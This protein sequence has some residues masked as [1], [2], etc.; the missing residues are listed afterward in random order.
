MNERFLAIPL[1]RAR[2]D[3]GDQAKEQRCVMYGAEERGNYKSYREVKVKDIERPVTILEVATEKR[4]E[5]EEVQA[6]AV[7][8]DKGV[9]HEGWIVLCEVACKSG[10]VRTEYDKVIHKWAVV[11]QEFWDVQL[12][13]KRCRCGECKYEWFLGEWECPKELAIFIGLMPTEEGPSKSAKGSKEKK[14]AQHPTRGCGRW[15]EMVEEEAP[16]QSSTVDNATAVAKS[17]QK[18]EGKTKW[19]KATTARKCI[20][21]DDQE[22]KTSTEKAGD[23]AY[24]AELHYAAENLRHRASQLQRENKLVH[25]ELKRVQIQLDHKRTEVRQTQSE[26]Q[27]TIRMSEVMMKRKQQE[28]ESR[29][30][31]AEHTAKLCEEQKESL[32]QKTTH[33]QE[34]IQHQNKRMYDMEQAYNALKKSVEEETTTNK[35]ARKVY[36][37]LHG[38]EETIKT[39]GKGEAVEYHGLASKATTLLMMQAMAK[40]AEAAKREGEAQAKQCP[41][42]YNRKMD[43]VL[44]CGHA[45]CRACWNS[46]IIATRSDV[47]P[48]CR[49]P[50][51]QQQTQIFLC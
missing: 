21:V 19:R 18:G 30:R 32:L 14:V 7:F 43:L 45:I 4:K 42:C 23:E 3:E 12:K 41:I 51:S 48:M 9:K 22:A 50:I 39:L 15:V 38:K 17:S 26:L 49:K 8:E 46:M 35:V 37:I 27:E 2:T 13:R 40:E 29:I 33:Q 5:C 24:M 25:E 16:S 47:C 1:A 31:K 11:K 28:M 20:D 44:D 36:H 34:I 10:G 6:K